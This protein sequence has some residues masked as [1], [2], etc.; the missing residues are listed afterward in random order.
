LND[1]ELEKKIKLE[2]NLPLGKSS[3]TSDG[4]KT[5]LLEK[6]RS[7]SGF[8][9]FLKKIICCWNEVNYGNWKY[10]RRRS[11]NLQLNIYL[12]IKNWSYLWI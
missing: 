10:S 4:S 3:L 2:L 1:P 12:L 6:S 8:K 7:E 5:L 9:R 11:V